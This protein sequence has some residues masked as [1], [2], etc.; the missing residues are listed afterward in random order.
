M[1]RGDCLTWSTKRFRSMRLLCV[2]ITA[3]DS[4]CCDLNLV[5][6][7][8]RRERSART[9]ENEAQKSGEKEKI[10][11]WTIERMGIR[12]SVYTAERPDQ[13]TLNNSSRKRDSLL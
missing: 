11:S 2:V 5:N 8:A 4:R 13:E 12:L 6:I 7:L 9:R 10:G 1:E 3:A